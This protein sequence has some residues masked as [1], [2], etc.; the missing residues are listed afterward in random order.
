M[1]KII[2]PNCKSEVILPEKSEM[3]VGMTISEESKGEYEL[4]MKEKTREEE[5]ENKN[6]SN[7][8][9]MNF[10]FDMNVLAK[11]VAEQIV[12]G[13]LKGDVNNTIQNDNEVQNNNEKTNIIGNNVNDSNINTV[14]DGGKWAKGSKLYGKEI[15]G[16]MF[17]PYMIRWHLQKQFE[18]LMNRY[19]NN[20]FRG[21]SEEY[22]YMY[23]IKYTLEEVRKLAMLHKKDK[24]AFEERALCFT[25]GE[26]KKIFIDYFKDVKD[27]LEQKEN[28][29]V[30]DN[31]VG[32]TIYMS[33]GNDWK[34][35]FK[36]GVVSEKIVKHKVVK[37]LEK[38][39]EYK[40]IIIELE[41]TLKDLR[42]TYSYD[43]LYKFMRDKKYIIPNNTK[44]SKTFMDCFIKSGSYY[45]LK[46]MLMFNENISFRGMIGRN[47]VIE[48]RRELNR[49]CLKGYQF[50]GMLKEVK[51]I[52]VHRNYW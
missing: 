22:T 4:P 34:R 35:N 42:F 18:D 37:Y 16:F 26:C 33:I 11:M 29:L 17:N 7:M 19:D 52:K 12:T 15:C 49:D 46:Q 3:V 6:M 40:A 30:N 23:S 38:S 48:L 50:Y 47:A 20:V 39:V 24:L 44:K 5:K 32:K 21:I 9:G 31:G 10:D 36:A 45:T 13:Q 8:N 2:C 43:N 51:G 28:E 41:R 27:Y 1:A 25:L 14:Q